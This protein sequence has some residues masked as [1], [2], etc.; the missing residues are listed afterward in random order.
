MN[1]RNSIFL[2]CVCVSGVL[3]LTAESDIS[4]DW[5]LLDTITAQIYQPG[6]MDGADIVLLS[7]TLSKGLDG[8]VKKLTEEV[9]HRL[10]LADAER[11]RPREEM[12]PDKKLDEYIRRIPAEELKYALREMGMTS[13]QFREADCQPNINTSTIR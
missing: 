2:S 9:Y 3:G 8:R 4:S 10:I 5:F 11:M 13:V 1:V 6:S 12:I 7:D